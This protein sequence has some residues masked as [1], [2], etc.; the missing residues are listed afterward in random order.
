[1]ECYQVGGAVRDRLLG[2]P[3]RDRD[4]VV[5]GASP[6]EM[7][8]LGYRSVG[9]D[10]PVFL[11][12]ETQEEYALARTERK[13]GRGYKGFAFH[14]GPEVTLE[15][16]LQ[17]RDLTINAMAQT[18]AGEI[19]DPYGGQADLQ[20][21]I[22]RHVSA[23]F[24]EDP[25]RVL[26]VARFAARLGFTVAEKTLDLMRK[27]AASGEL[28]ALTA[29]RVWMEWRRALQEPQPAIFFQ[30]LSRCSSLEPLFPPALGTPQALATLEAAGRGGAAPEVRFAAHL[31]A[32]LP[33]AAAAKALAG[34]YRI[35]KSYGQLAELAL[36]H[37][38]VLDEDPKASWRA[39]D[40]LTL[41]RGADAWRRKGR[42]EMLLETWKWA[43]PAKTGER[44]LQLLRQACEAARRA[45]TH[46]LRQADLSGEALGHAIERR[47]E[48][49]IRKR[50][51]K[52]KSGL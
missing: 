32:A 5:I 27:L 1:M 23:A 42:F 49:A 26:R 47:R 2:R 37:R 48:E 46:T 11:H 9:K 45:E 20:A 35:P 10:F 34:R 3:V 6:E 12:P 14:T 8:R 41:L 38:H 16:D 50:L 43:I 13:T 7:T 19:V 25:L 22:L 29:E 30:V 33:D 51:D 18:T 21:G 28:S 36:A 44:R 24:V 52:E 4:W 17:R 15:Q 40:I 31:A 39:K